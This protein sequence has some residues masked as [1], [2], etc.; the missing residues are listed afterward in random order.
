MIVFKTLASV[1][2]ALGFPAETLYAVSNNLSRHYHKVQI[3]KKDGGVRTLSVP[4][5]ILKSIQRAIV[6]KLLWNEPVS[7]YAKAYKFGTS[8]KKNAMPHVGRGTLLKLDIK[9]FFDSILYSC[10]KER[11][12]PSARFSEPIRILL[13]M[14]CYFG[15][16]L[17]QGAPSS[18]VITNII[19]KDFDE[20][21]GFWCRQRRIVYTRYCDDM[22]FS[23]VE[24]PEE[25][26]SFVSAELRREG[27]FL[28][29]RKTVT[30]PPSCRQTVTGVVVNDKLNAPK[31]YRRRIRK[32]I[33]F[34]KKYGV[35]EHLRHE[36]STQS[37]VGYLRSLLGRVNYVLQISADNAEFEEYRTF[38]K[39]LLREEQKNVKR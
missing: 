32:E 33:Y 7:I 23:G 13:T 5:E 1:E 19:M 18:P 28:N 9:G 22:S 31:D 34:C 26:I 11:V 39:E 2:Q 35:A 30:V 12:F 36:G 29:E 20:R 37:A 24:S 10:V 16:A 6:E 15:E 27:Y 8:V 17:P 38:V 4:D 25:V 3:P 14:L 21:V